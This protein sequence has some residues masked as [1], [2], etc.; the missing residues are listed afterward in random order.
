MA[1]VVQ[2]MTFLLS[3]NGQMPLKAQ[4][5]LPLLHT[6]LT[7]QPAVAGGIGKLLTSRLL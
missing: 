4:K 5:A 7:H 1:L 2:V 3:L 6:T